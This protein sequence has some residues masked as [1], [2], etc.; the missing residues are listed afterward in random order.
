MFQSSYADWYQADNR[1]IRI[2]LQWNGINILFNTS[3]VPYGFLYIYYAYLLI[4]CESTSFWYFFYQIQPAYQSI[5][6]EC[7]LLLKKTAM[8]G[9]YTTWHK[10]KRNTIVKLLS[11]FFY[12]ELLSS[13]NCSLNIAFLI[14]LHLALLVGVDSVHIFSRIFSL[15]YD[16]N[17]SFKRGPL[18]LVVPSVS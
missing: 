10:S 15:E 11:K 1:S 12:K 13:F 6:I 5:K 18:A 2:K 4:L 14:K 17:S 16:T 7:A 9:I 8:K 3:Q